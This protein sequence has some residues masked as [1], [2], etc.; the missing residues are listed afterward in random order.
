MLSLVTVGIAVG[1]GVEK[2][3]SVTVWEE[4]GSL[5]ST[6][7]IHVVGKPVGASVGNEDGA[8][9]EQL[10]IRIYL[11][12]LLSPDLHPARNPPIH[13]SKCQLSL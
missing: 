8:V 1:D 5:V 11:L 13:K 6:V 12:L 4:D 2:T 9:G 10:P 3:D 7:G